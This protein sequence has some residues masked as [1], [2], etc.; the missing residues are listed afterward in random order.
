M[1]VRLRS[2]TDQNTRRRNIRAA[3]AVCLFLL[4][5]VTLV[6]GQ[7]LWHG[8]INIDDQD[9]VFRN[10]E[11][12]S[13]LTLHGAQWAFT[14]KH[15]ANWHPLTWLSHMLDCQLYGPHAEAGHDGAEPT[16]DRKRECESF[17]RYAWG[18]HLTSV[19][20]HAANAIL[21]F[22]VL[23]RMTGD[24]WPAAFVAAV[25]A[26]HPLRVESVAWVSERKDLLSGLFFVLTLAAYV[27]CVRRPFS[28]GRYLLV[29]G[30]F[31]LGLMAKPMLVTLPPL[32]L[33]LDYWPLGRTPLSRSAGAGG[34]EAS[35]QT[36][37]PPCPPRRLRPR[38]PNKVRFPRRHG[39]G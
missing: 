23:W 20:L 25:F 39:H 32:L 21:L 37:R 17:A 18:H 19:L 5:A 15:S 7:T 11:V 22:L 27:G 29:V 35:L 9:Y 14:A 31:A 3:A 30:T 38:R 1:T 24:L 6:F 26:V 33:L 13:G 2:S 4:L 34:A 8:F 36:P 12:K 10:D 28:W 16:L